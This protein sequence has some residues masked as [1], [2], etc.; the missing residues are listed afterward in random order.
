MN[1]SLTKIDHIK[2]KQSKFLLVRT[3]RIGDVILSTPVARVLKEH[4]PKMEVH[5]LVRNYTLPIVED[6]PFVN[7][8]W[9]EEEFLSFSSKIFF[10][11]K[12]QFDGIIFL[13]PEKDW[14]FASFLARIKIRIGTGY[15][16]YSIFFNKKVFIHRKRGN[17]HEADLN[18]QLLQSLKIKQATVKFDFFIPEIAIEKVN[19]E[20]IK[21]HIPEKFVVLHPGSGGSAL[22]WP[23]NKFAEL[24]DLIDEKLYIS[25]VFTGSQQETELVDEVLVN[26]KRKH[27]RL[28]GKFNLK[29]L[30][31]LLQKATLTVA[32]STGPLH[33]AVAVGTKVIGLY[34]PEK[35]CHPNRWGPYGQKKSVL[36]PPIEKCKICGKSKCEHFS[37]MELISVDQVFTKIKEKLGS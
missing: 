22:D 1:E 3:D 9:I 33:L 20:L 16:A 37:C 14:A 4:F 11:K 12:N 25:V 26:T 27:F 6:H 29:Q 31:A 13:H 32:N 21:N 36:L 15:R 7:K 5:F 18:L 23:L 34:S 19:E 2:N 28:D 10:L 35:A 8:I 30:A 17:Q 24:A